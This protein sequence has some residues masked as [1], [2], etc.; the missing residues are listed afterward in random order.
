[1]SLSRGDSPLFRGRQTTRTQMN[2]YNENA[3]LLLM[4]NTLVKA[5]GLFVWVYTSSHFGC[6]RIQRLLGERK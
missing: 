6:V 5:T 4:K 2:G 1:M 3:Y